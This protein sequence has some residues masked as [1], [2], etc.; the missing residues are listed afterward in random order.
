MRVK[1]EEVVEIPGF[2]CYNEE[3]LPV[4]TPEV[5]SVTYLLVEIK[6][7]PKRVDIKE[8]TLN[9]FLTPSFED[10][11]YTSEEENLKEA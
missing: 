10:K 6:K 3:K 2:F 5:S 1:P 11:A 4:T 9:F 7:M 8:D